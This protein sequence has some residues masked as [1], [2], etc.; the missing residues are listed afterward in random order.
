MFKRSKKEVVPPPAAAKG[1]K[2]TNQYG[3]Q[4]TPEEIAAGAHR[5]FVGGMWDEIGKLQLEFLQ[6]QGLQPAHKLLDVGCGALRGGI[7]FAQFL[8][9]GR[10][11][12]IDL[13]ASLIEAGKTELERS[14]LAGKNA[15]L[16]VDGE[17]K[18]SRFGE[19]FDFLIAVSVFTHLFGQHVVRALR[20]AS[21]VLAPA[22]RFYATFFIAPEPAHLEPITHERGG[23]TTKYDSDPFHYGF[24][25]IEALSGFAGLHARL[26]GEWNHPR[27]QQMVCFTLPA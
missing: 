24:P 17:F 16:L 21:H 18:M 8:Q 13:N 27:N 19:K 15:Q 20:E 10:Y 4:L 25:E 26:I 3:R 12:G 14:G 1:G 23:I 9:P 2:P 22:G 5:S 6:G 7:H 11:Y